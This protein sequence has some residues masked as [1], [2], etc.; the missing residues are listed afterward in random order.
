MSNNVT[1]DGVRRRLGS[2]D[3]ID[4]EIGIAE[5]AYDQRRDGEHVEEDVRD[6][7]IEALAAHLIASGAERQIDSGGE[8]DGSVTFAGD[9]GMGLMATTH[10]Q[11]AVLLDPTGQ[12]D[13]GEDGDSD[14]V[15]FSG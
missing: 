9:T 11:M 6:D 15:V 4:A 7:V 5:R 2:S 14:D 1:A 10:G 8:G 3:L 12:L 13:G